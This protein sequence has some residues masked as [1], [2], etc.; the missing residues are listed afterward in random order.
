MARRELIS[1]PNFSGRSG[2]LMALLRDGAFAPE[3]FYIGPYS[4]AALS[5]LSSTIAD[6]IELYGAMKTSFRRPPFS[7][8]DVAAFSHARAADAVGRRAGAARAALLLAQRLPGARGRHRA[9]A[10]RPGQ[11]RRRARLSRPAPQADRERRADRQPPAAAAPRLAVHGTRGGY[12]RLRLRSAPRG[13][14]PAAPPGA[15]DRDPRAQLRL[16][17]RQ[18]HLPRRRSRARRRRRLPARRAERRRQDHAAQAPGRRARAERRRVHARHRAVPAMA[19]GQPG[20]RA[21]DPEPGPPMVRRDAARRPRPAALRLRALGRS[22][23][24]G[25]CADGSARRRARHPFARRAPLR[26]AARG[27]QAA[28]LAVAAVGRA[29]LGDAR[30]AV[31]RP[32]FRDA[33]AARRRDRPPHRARLR[34]AVRHPRRR[35]R[36]AASRTAC[37]RSAMRR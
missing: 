14:R 10:A 19:A 6:E 16:S 37:W 15:G 20:V 22:R 27:A 4:E 2:A 3:S 30:R 17:P 33:G 7:L 32:G 24:G 8:L 25:G 29:A 13:R 5:G 31:D 1:G 36:R 21:R 28:E 35:F 12:G 34:R 18:G 26:A 9:R 23:A 11:P